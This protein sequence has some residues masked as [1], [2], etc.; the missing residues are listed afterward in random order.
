MRACVHIYICEKCNRIYI[1]KY[2]NATRKYV[3][4][5]YV[6]HPTVSFFR[7][8]ALSGIAAYAILIADG[9]NR[10]SPLPVTR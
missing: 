10:V 5:V 1:I 6:I 3:S 8:V 4:K 9:K 2:N 7:S